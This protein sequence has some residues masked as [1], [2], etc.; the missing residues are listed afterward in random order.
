MVTS[1]ENLM[2]YL[3]KKKIDY[4]MNRLDKL[5]AEVNCLEHF[6]VEHLGQLLCGIYP[7]FDKQTSA[8]MQHYARTLY[9][10]HASNE[11]LLSHA[12]FEGFDSAIYSDMAVD[13]LHQNGFSLEDEEDFGMVEGKLKDVRPAHDLLISGEISVPFRAKFIVP[14]VDPDHLVSALDYFITRIDKSPRYLLIIK[15]LV[16][17]IP[18]GNLMIA[19]KISEDGGKKTAVLLPFAQNTQFYYD[20]ATSEKFLPQISLDALRLLADMAK[21]G[22]SVNA[23]MLLEEIADTGRPGNPFVGPL[24]S[25]L[26]DQIVADKRRE[27]EQ[28]KSEK[29]NA[30]VEPPVVEKEIPVVKKN[31]SLDL[32]TPSEEVQAIMRRAAASSRGLAI[33]SDDD[34]E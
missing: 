8:V 11:L 18:D 9:I 27:R 34:D 2:R 28:T 30:K 14:I 22:D 10:D 3:D 19:R 25:E 5:L 1:R 13:K 32:Y 17:R 12:L 4:P 15:A 26:H 23:L 20:A 31:I 33:S 7:F 29:K 21:Q 16:A 6:S 24:A